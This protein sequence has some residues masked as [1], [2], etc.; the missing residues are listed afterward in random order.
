MC[1]SQM[2]I[3]VNTLDPRKNVRAILSYAV[4]KVH[5]VG[6]GSSGAAF[7]HLIRSENQLPLKTK[8]GRSLFESASVEN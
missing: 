3:G 7:Y 1:Q 8:V 6:F 4:C 5:S 2:R